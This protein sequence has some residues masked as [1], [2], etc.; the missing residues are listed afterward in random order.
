MKENTKTP[1]QTQDPAWLIWNTIQNKEL[2][3]L[4]PSDFYYPEILQ[5]IRSN[6]G[7]ENFMNSL[8][9]SNEQ[10]IIERNELMKFLFDHEKL[11]EEL[12]A[13]LNYTE[14]NVKDLPVIENDFLLFYKKENAY[15]KLIE[16]F[17][18][19]MRSYNNLPKKLLPFLEKMEESFKELPKMEKAMADNVSESLKKVTRLEGCLEIEI[20]SSHDGYG[21]KSC[22]DFKTG[23]EIIIGQKRFNAT[24]SGQYRTEL[25]KWSKN[26]PCKILGIQK[27]IQEKITKEE[28]IRAK[29]SSMITNF[30]DSIKHD[31]GKFLIEKINTAI[32][33]FATGNMAIV[34]KKLAK[35]ALKKLEI[36][37]EKTVVNIYFRY[38]SNG[39]RITPTSIKSYKEEISDLFDSDVFFRNYDSY[40][41]EERTRIDTIIS[42]I[43]EDIDN[44]LAENNGVPID[45]FFRKNLGI[46]IGNFATIP[47]PK[48]D[49]N[50]R[51]SFL[52]NL[53]QSSENKASYTLLLNNRKYFWDRIEELNNLSLILNQFEETA[54]EK[55]IPLCM[56]KIET[57][58]VGVRFEKMAPINMMEQDK[59]MVPFSFPEINGHIICL[60]GKHG[61]GKSVAGSSILENLW[62]AQSGLPVFAEQ[63]ETDIKEIIGAVI[64][65]NGEGSTA[66]VFLKKTL[67]L[68]KNI[69]KVPSHKSLIFID[70]IGKGTQESSGFEFGQKVLKKLS[71][72]GNSV[73]FNTQIIKLAEYAKDNLGAICL[74][75][76]DKHQFQPGIGEGMM[77]E[78]IH[79]IGLDKYLK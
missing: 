20:T 77:K 76:N 14:P 36:F 65:D 66:T 51:W 29:R 15:W 40:T 71:E 31:I 39:L 69:E 34:S 44:S 62:L 60:T 17:I 79:E 1:E 52:Q 24:W 23:H 21:N 73:V 8:G 55:N 49:S 68:F 58:R 6:I 42:D 33:G 70:E 63:F 11:R 53:Y 48:T 2:V 61:R 37:D 28:K 27:Y 38:D 32:F 5:K 18:K 64:N 74:K 43:D 54:R 78:L 41:P 57:K 50:F 16:H 25:P 72:N 45:N 47:S 19:T 75:V 59:K 56:P 26:W 9:I 4:N 10:E 35:N 13:L 22:L 3:I 67:N 30:P 7:S 12:Y 46:F